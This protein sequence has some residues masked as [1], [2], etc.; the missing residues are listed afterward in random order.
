MEDR[1]CPT[2]GTVF[3]PTHSRNIYCG[4]ACRKDEHP[5]VEKRCDCCGAT[6][7]KERRSQRY[8]S[9]YCSQLC[10]DYGVYGAPP[11]CTLPTD[12]WARWYGRTSKWVAP[13]VRN[14]GECQWCG[15]PNSRD[16]SAAYCSWSCKQKAKR[17]RR[18]AT[19]FGAPGEYTWTQVMTQYRR[20]GYVCAYCR[21]KIKGLPEPEHVV[22]LSR[23]GRND[24]TNIVAACKQC[25]SDKRDLMLSEWNVDRQ[26][27][28]LTA[29]KTNL[30]GPE[31]IRLTA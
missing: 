15:A 11:A 18:R 1:T 16:Q 26:R 22:P 7:L 13:V 31:F 8:E 23:G 10:R 2:C 3:T 17:Q 28:G 24:M 19:E 4:P 25:N 12:H 27:R 20:Q 6:C 21:Q 29:V 9:T 14:T 5:K 30:H